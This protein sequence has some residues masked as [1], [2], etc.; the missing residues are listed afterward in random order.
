M[1]VNVPPIKSQ[2][3]K[4][5]GSDSFREAQSRSYIMFQIPVWI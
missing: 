2:G 3:I 4:T 1:Q 5:N